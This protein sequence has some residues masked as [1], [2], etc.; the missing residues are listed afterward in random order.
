MTSLGSGEERPSRI[1]TSALDGSVP[2]G[3]SPWGSRLALWFRQVLTFLF[4]KLLAMGLRP[5][6]VLPFFKCLQ[7][8]STQPSLLRS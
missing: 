7:S 1:Y 8:L 2:K 5:S 3:A 6:L 4:S